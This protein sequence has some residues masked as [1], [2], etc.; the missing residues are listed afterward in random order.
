MASPDNQ[1]IAG[2]GAGFGANSWLV[3]EMYER[4]VHDPGSVG[5]QWQEFFADYKTTAPS[6]AAAAAASP[7]VRAVEAAYRPPSDG[8]GDLPKP[9]DSAA[10]AKKPPEQPAKAE[11]APEAEPAEEAGKPIRGA[12]A[13]IV[14]NM[15][16][17][18][19]VPTATS[20]R[21]VPAKLLEVNR[22][23]INGFRSR[24]GQ[25]KISFTHLIGWAVVRAIADEV[26]NM[27]NGFLE[28]D[29]GKPR[30]V[31]NDHV[32]MALAVDVE[33]KDGSRTLLTPIIRDADTLDFAGFLAAYD[34][35]IRKVKSNK[36]TVDDFMGANVSL[37]NPGTIGTVQSVPRLM[38]GQG[39]IVGVGSIDFP[40]EFEGADRASLADMG[41][42]KTVTVTSTYDHRIIQGAESGL[43]L[44]RVKELLLG[45]HE[46]YDEI[47]QS[48]DLPYEA[49]KWRPD[50][51]PRDRE[52]AMMRKQMAVAKL[53]RVHRVR[54]HRIADLDPAA[55]DRATHPGRTRPRHLRPHHLGPRS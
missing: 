12:G 3:D 5:E 31:T 37:T 42:S 22:K 11:P 17:S 28:G 46:F 2:T 49:V 29:D 16:A 21:N 50:I 4:F 15:E 55:V 20:F 19:E 30:L 54:G 10:P 25:G 45:E 52:E 47:F 8:S 48:L 13:A 18:L 36:L 33:K 43:F 38:P 34:E 44:K 1:T 6:V 23:V 27:K 9:G 35:L 7:E 51:N 24:S 41:L 39:L 53:I 26:P 32:N 14:R 40:A